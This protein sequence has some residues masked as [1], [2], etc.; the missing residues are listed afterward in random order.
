MQQLSLFFFLYYSLLILFFTDRF[1]RVSFYI[2]VYKI[3]FIHLFCKQ[4]YKMRVKRNYQWKKP[5]HQNPHQLFGCTENSLFSCECNKTN[6]MYVSIP[7]ILFLCIRTA[8]VGSDRLFFTFF[9]DLFYKL[10]LFLTLNIHRF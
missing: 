4:I 8:D 2:F 3:N 1:F 6:K 7:S 10:I 5:P 9:T